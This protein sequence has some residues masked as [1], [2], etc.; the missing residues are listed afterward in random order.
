MV[1]LLATYPP[2][3]IA[4]LAR[5]YLQALALKRKGAPW[6]AHPAGAP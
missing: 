6:F 4:T 2:L 5:I 1:R 3:T